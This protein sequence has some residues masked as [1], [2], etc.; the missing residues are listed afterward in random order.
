M[1]SDGFT[2]VITQ[3]SELDGFCVSSARPHHGLDDDRA[4]EDLCIAFLRGARDVRGSTT[5]PPY[6]QGSPLTIFS[7]Q[8]DAACYINQDQ[9]IHSLHPYANPPLLF[10]VH[11]RKSE[12]GSSQKRG[13]GT[14]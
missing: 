7:L 2:A 1:R 12:S 6:S 13:R 9:L 8:I 11:L 5:Q 10:S 3:Y 14:L 4:Q